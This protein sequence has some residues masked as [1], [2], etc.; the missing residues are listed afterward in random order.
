MPHSDGQTSQAVSACLAR[1]YSKPARVIRFPRALRKSSGT[2]TEPRLK[3]YLVKTKCNQLG[4][5]QPSRHRHVDHGPVRS[6]IPIRVDGSGTSR[7]ALHSSA[8]KWF[9][10][11]I[12]VFIRGMLRICRICSSAEGTRYSMKCM[13]NLIPVRRALRV[14]ARLPRV[15]W[16]SSRNP[17]TSRASNC[18][19]CRAE[20]RTSSLRLANSNRSW[21]A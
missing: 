19:S 4:N 18:S 14:R 5:T 12:S 7:I 2:G 9:T 16:R 17:S 1:R 13:N 20:G 11:R 15:V 10:R 6:R 3:G 21:N 8:V